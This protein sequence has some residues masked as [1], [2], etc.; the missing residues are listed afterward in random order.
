MG[1]TRVAYVLL[2]Q[3]GRAFWG[4][5]MS[6]CTVVLMSQMVLQRG[7]AFWGAEM[8]FPDLSLR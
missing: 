1:K 2:L 5:E 4:A 3:R 6:H 7:R 8:S